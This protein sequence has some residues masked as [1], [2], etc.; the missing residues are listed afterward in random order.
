MQCNS[1][2]DYFDETTARGLRVIT[3]EKTFLVYENKTKKTF[4]KKIHKIQFHKKIH[5]IQFHK[6]KS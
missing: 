2:F 3:F 1:D 4:H 5:K 6:K